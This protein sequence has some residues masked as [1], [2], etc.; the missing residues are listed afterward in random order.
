MVCK[1]YQPVS[2][3]PEAARQKQLTPSLVARQFTTAQL[4]RCLLVNRQ[5]VYQLSWE[6]K[7]PEQQRRIRAFVD[8]AAITL[9]REMA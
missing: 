7:T 1:K 5:R 4:K 6:S 8:A 9:R 3:T 2:K